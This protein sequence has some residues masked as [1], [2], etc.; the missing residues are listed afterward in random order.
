[1]RRVLF[2][3][4]GRRICSYPACLYIGLNLGMAAQNWAARIAGANT[5][6][7]Y[8]AADRKERGAM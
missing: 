7:V 1:M 6:R 5:W 4:R 8:A 2:V 3:W